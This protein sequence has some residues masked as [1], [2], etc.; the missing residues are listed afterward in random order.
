MLKDSFS[1]ERSFVG[2]LVPLALGVLG[3]GGAGFWYF[4]SSADSA[5]SAPMGME[6]M[7]AIVGA[8]AGLFAGALV[9]FILDRV[10][11]R[12]HRR[13]EEF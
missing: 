9:G 1:E 3:G 5:G 10:M 11:T 6:F 7:G 13:E 2:C 12:R 8:C 4:R